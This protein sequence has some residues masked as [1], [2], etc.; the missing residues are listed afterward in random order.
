[1]LMF[2]KLWWPT[3]FV[4]GPKSNSVSG[5]TDIKTISKCKVNQTSGLQAT[6]FTSNILHR[7]Q[8]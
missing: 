3:F 7:V 1:M 2:Q 5:I 8:C 6:A 4:E